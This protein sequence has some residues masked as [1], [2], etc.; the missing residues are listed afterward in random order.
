VAGPQ[1]SGHE[2]DA[3][4]SNGLS[5]TEGV[6]LGLFRFRRIAGPPWLPGLLRL[7]V[8][9]CLLLPAGMGVPV[10]V[11]RETVKA[12]SGRVYLAMPTCTNGRVVLPSAPYLQQ[13]KDEG[14]GAQAGPIDEAEVG[15]RAVVPR[16]RQA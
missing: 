7:P 16:L 10:S 12:T 11:A 6:W 5:A 3:P 13:V 14:A 1:A 8:E 9:H 2:A 15:C 4:P